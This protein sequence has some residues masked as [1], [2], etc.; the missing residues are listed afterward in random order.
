LF[1]LRQ[2]HADGAFPARHAIPVID[3]SIATHDDNSHAA[4]ATVKPR[5][6]S[7]LDGPGTVAALD[8]QSRCPFYPSFPFAE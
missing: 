5:I 4:M 6:A 7:A 2:Q 3:I 1:D 8:L